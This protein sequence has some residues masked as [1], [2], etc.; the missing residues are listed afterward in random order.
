MLVGLGLVLGACSSVDVPLLSKSDRERVKEA[1]GP[2]DRVET[3][4]HEPQLQKGQAGP[5]LGDWLSDERWT[6]TWDRPRG[7][8][9]SASVQFLKG[10]F[11]GALTRTGEV[12]REY[13]G[14]Q[15][16]DLA[17]RDLRLMAGLGASVP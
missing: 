14:R 10:E 12:Q 5:L 6:Y 9:A 1:L 3:G 15:Q 8:K 2:P 17:I 13:K 11:Q 4:G 7:T 16:L